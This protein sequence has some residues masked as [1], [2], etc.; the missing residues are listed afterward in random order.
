MASALEEQVKAQQ[1]VIEFLR[2]K[3]EH[4]TGRNLALPTSLGHLLGDASIQGGLTEMDEEEEKKK[5]A[6]QEVSY[7]TAKQARNAQQN[8]FQSLTF[9]EAIET[10]RLPKVEV[11][12]RGQ[13][14]GNKR[15]EI[16]F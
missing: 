10:L 6:D 11:Q 15:K 4:D 12:A 9:M 2:S 5:C 1:K 3:Y 8:Q 7:Q 13:R 16:R 14:G